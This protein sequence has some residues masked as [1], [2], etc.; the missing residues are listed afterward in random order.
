MLL[1]KKL[2]NTSHRGDIVYGIELR[3]DIELGGLILNLHRV[4][5]CM[6]ATKNDSRAG[7]KGW[8]PL[9]R[10]RNSEMYFITGFWLA[11]GNSNS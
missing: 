10:T 7:D 3:G 4:D 8:Y 1:Y 5:N 6:S 11:E 2:L 9:L